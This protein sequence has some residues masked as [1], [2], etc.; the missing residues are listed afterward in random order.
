MNPLF[1]IRL[2]STPVVISIQYLECTQHQ[3]MDTT[4]MIISLDLGILDFP[5]G[6]QHLTHHDSTYVV[7]QVSHIAF[8]RR[9]SSVY[10]SRFSANKY[11]DNGHGTF[12][13]LVDEER[14][15]GHY[16]YSPGTCC[17]NGDATINLEL[18]AG[19]IVRI[20]NGFSTTILGTFNGI[21]RS[22][23]TGHLLYAL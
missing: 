11:G 16:E 14:V 3:L 8:I 2:Q 22:W 17:L 23:F 15:A 9:R 4:R 7:Y 21:M 18:S 6:L 1:G 19:Q 5:D 12:L 20:E 13:F 10:I